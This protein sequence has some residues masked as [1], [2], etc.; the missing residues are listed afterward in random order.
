M[1]GGGGGATT[2]ASTGVIA[3]ISTKAEA[4]AELELELERLRLLGNQAVASKDWVTAEEYYSQGLELVSKNEALY[5]SS[6]KTTNK[7]HTIKVV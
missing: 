5:S 3:A 7:F 2:A 6:G 4:D 1:E